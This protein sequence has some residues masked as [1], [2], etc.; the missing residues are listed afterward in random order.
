MSFAVEDKV[1]TLRSRVA[2]AH[3]F[4]TDRNVTATFGALPGATFVTSGAAR[5]AD[6]LLTSASAELKFNNGWTLSGTVDGEFS[7]T[8]RSYSGRGAVRYAW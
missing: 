7:K 2:W 5:A 8:T 4:N 3:D 6:A 1:F